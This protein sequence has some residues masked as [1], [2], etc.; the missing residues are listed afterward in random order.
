[1]GV[2]SEDVSAT[3]FL[4]LSL[5]ATNPTT[6]TPTISTATRIVA[7]IAPEFDFFLGCNR[8]W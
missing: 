8:C 6:A 7:T 4:F 5:T 1:V 2:W 3:A